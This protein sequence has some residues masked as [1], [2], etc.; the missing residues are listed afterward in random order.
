MSKKLRVHHIF[1]T[2]LYEGKGYSNSFCDNMAAVV[3]WLRSHPDEKLTLS[4]SPDI[5]CANC[6]NH[7]P[8][9]ICSHNGNRVV[10]KD[11]GIAKCLELTE[12]AEYTY[13]EL[14]RRAKECVTEEV[15][16]ETCGNCDWRKQ[17]LCR[18]EDL[19][20]QLENILEK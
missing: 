18:Y 8:G 1:C 15:F 5:V 7:L 12:G 2:S 4:A 19:V 17:G 20:S 11:R 16:M 9:D 13:R 10:D 6:P 14:C 3:S